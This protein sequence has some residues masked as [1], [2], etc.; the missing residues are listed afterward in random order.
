MIPSIA[1]PAR[2]VTQTAIAFAK[3]GSARPVDDENPLPIG[4]VSYSQAR[5]A[6]PDTALDPGRA[7][8]IVATGP[9]QV[10]I[11]LANGGTV[12]LP[13]TA[14]VTLLPFAVAAITALDGAERAVFTLLD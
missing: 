11:E 3:A 10:L 12:A 14:G 5:P 8:M 13:V 1:S 6:I 7:L 9:G 2:Y 4:E